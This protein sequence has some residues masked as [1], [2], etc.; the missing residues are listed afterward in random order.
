MAEKLNFQ[1]IQSIHLAEKAIKAFIVAANLSI[2]F[3][4]IDSLISNS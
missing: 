2:S 4:Y 3:L 1:Y